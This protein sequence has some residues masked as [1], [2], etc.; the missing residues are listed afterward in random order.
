MIQRI[1]VPKDAR[2]LAAPSDA[3]PRRLTSDLD[4]RTLVPS[5]LPHIELDGHTSIPSYLPL[6]VLGERTVVPRDMP[7]TP[8]DGIS[9][10]P[11]YVPLTILDSRIAVPKDAHASKIEPKQLVAIQDLPDVLDPDVLTTGEVNLMAQPLEEK[12]SAWNA[13]ARF[14]S[15][16]LHFVVI[17]LILFGPRVFPSQP[18]TRSEIA[19]DNITD[20]YL[21]NDVRDVP[22]APVTPQPKSPVMRVDPRLLRKLA[23]PRELQPNPSPP[24]P[25]HVVRDT[26]NPS[27]ALSAPMPQPRAQPLPESP[28]KPP[29]TPPDA[30]TSSLVLPRFSPGKAL[31]ENLHQALKDGGTA[32]AQFGG[33]TGPT[34]GGGM[35]GYGGGAGQGY[36]GGA[37]QMLTPTEGV[38]FTNYLARVLA[39]VKR[40]WYA[41]MPESAQLGEKGKVVLQFR[42]MKNGVVPDAEPAMV[43]T[44]GKDPLDRAAVSSIRASTPFEPLPPAFSG[45][46]IELRFIFLYNI[47]L[48][49]AQ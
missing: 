12:T 24:E 36:L 10:M 43:G 45:P 34:G 9:K 15:V 7:S 16:A 41:V 20:L 11:D 31:Q 33:P 3:P 47:P 27:K 30:P 2:P 29:Q 1:L 14:A 46:Y 35:G 18:S 28:I 39:S 21:P 37:L 23:P 44:S 13:V 19:R 4:A 42:I 22:K 48:N 25:E 32:G 17:L 5:N 40:N 49:A 6:G 8:L 38:D 26:P